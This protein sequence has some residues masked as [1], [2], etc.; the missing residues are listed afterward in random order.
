MTNNEIKYLCEKTQNQVRCMQEVLVEL[1]DTLQ[2]IT[3]DMDD[4][5][6]ALYTTG[7]SLENESVK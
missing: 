4:V 6:I 2:M 3:M 5:K 1:C 7:K